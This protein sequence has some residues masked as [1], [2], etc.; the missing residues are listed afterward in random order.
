MRVHILYANLKRIFTFEGLSLSSDTWTSMVV[1]AGYETISLACFRL[2]P[3][4]ITE[5]HQWWDRELPPL[6]YEN[7]RET[8]TAAVIT[9][10]GRF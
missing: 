1:R 9:I 5:L 3:K 6:V 4:K 10:E 7:L 2:I 8:D